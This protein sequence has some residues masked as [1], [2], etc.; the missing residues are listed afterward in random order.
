[1]RTKCLLLIISFTLSS[2]YNY[3]QNIEWGFK[4]G[5]TYE[6]NAL[7]IT[8][9]SLGNIYL[10]GGISNTVNANPNGSPHYVEASGTNSMDVFVAKYNSDFALLW[11][12]SIGS[13]SWESGAKIM[14]DDSLNVYIIGEGFGNIDFD[15]TDEDYFLDCSPTNAFIAK[16]SEEGTFKS[17]NK[18]PSISIYRSKIFIDNQNYIFTYSDDT[19]SKF[20]I[21]LQLIWKS[22]IEGN[23]ELFNKSEFHTIRNFRTHYYNF[24]WD[25]DELLFEKYDNINGTL[26]YSKQYAHCDFYVFGG[27][28]KKTKRDKLII[29]GYFWGNLS[30]YGN[31]QTIQVSNHDITWD[32]NMEVPQ[33][34]EFI[35][36]FDTTGNLLWA[37]AYDDKSPMPRLIET[38]SQGNIYTRGFLNFF[39]NFDPDSNIILTNNGYNDYIAKYDSTF[40]YQGTSLFLGGS[41]NDRTQGFTIYNDTALICGHFFNT[42][43]LDLTSASY[44]LSA[45]PPEDIFVA[46]YSDFTIEENPI[47]ISESKNELQSINIFP[48]PSI[49]IFDLEIIPFTKNATIRI[50]DMKANLI[51]TQLADDGRIKIDLS[52]YPS[53]LYF[54]QL[55]SGN[56]SIQK[57]I[58]KT[59]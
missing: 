33:P 57:T 56:S 40:S 37:K 10:I 47:N 39:A 30:F 17:V 59:D 55:I 52:K 22:R 31:N 7:D 46:K 14:V 58:I 34:R 27:I 11:A 9:D 36:M 43:D 32:G 53:S 8:N 23:P 1:M 48:N 51:H 41:Y 26:V 42:I 35:A 25:Q 24:D 18:I 19:L 12:F 29:S 44:T 16:Y 4:I 5:G 45:N 13:N 54:I 49:G 50:Y 3:A 2:F 21:N 6:D 38:D 28:V 20:D 15:P